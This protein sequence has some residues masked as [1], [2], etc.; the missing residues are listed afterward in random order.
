MV[1]GLMLVGAIGWRNI[2]LLT[3]AVGVLLSLVIFLFVREPVRGGTEPEL[4]AAAH[5]APTRFSWRAAGRLFRKRTLLFLF[6]NSF[7][8]VIPWQVITFWLFRYL[9]AERGHSQQGILVLMVVVVLVLAAGYPIGGALGDR[10]FRGNPRGRLMV[11][12]MG[13]L[14]GMIFLALA[15][16]GPQ[17]QTLRFQRAL[18]LAAL[19][20][21]LAGSNAIAMIYDVTVPEV[22]STATAV[23]NFMEQIGSVAAP[24]VAGL[25]AVHASLG[26]AILAICTGA[27]AICLVSSWWH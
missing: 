21:P 6:A 22:R 17:D 2:F 12:T 14:L 8:G 27:W 26:T 1:L 9:E 23:M 3:S 19:F 4:A 15:V 10:F 25:I 16:T 20:M 18:G 13:I 5:L 7:F 11:S 24:A